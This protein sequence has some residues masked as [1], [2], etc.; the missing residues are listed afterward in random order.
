[1]A[2]KRRF[3]N[4]GEVYDFLKELEAA[5]FNYSQSRAMYIPCEHERELH[6]KMRAKFTELDS[7]LAQVGEAW[8]KADDYIYAVSYLLYRERET[9]SKQELIELQHIVLKKKLRLARAL[10]KYKEE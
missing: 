6:S 9:V 8:R 1:M 3:F 10:L 5:V 4:P 7:M 2:W